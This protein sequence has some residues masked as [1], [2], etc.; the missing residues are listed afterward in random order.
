M[1]SLAD[2]IARAAETVRNGGPG[3]TA[4]TLAEWADIVSVAAE[5][6]HR[7][8]VAFEYIVDALGPN[9]EEIVD[10]AY[11]AA[12]ARIKEEANNDGR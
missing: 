6:D 8:E 10:D 1:R 9:A 11:E 7:H 4:A 2:E 3:P 5:D 12:D